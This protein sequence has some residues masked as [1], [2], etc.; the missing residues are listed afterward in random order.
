MASNFL[1]YEKEE[2]DRDCQGGVA[3]VHCCIECFEEQWGSKC[4][5]SKAEVESFD[6]GLSIFPRFSKAR[7]MQVGTDVDD[8]FCEFDQKEDGLEDQQVQLS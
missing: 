2:G 5:N 7:I 1:E 4:T 6:P 3:D 8:Y